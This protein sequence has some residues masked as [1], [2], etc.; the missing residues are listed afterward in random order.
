MPLDLAVLG[1]DPRFGGGGLAQTNAFLDGAAAL[2]R[3]PELLYDAHP[4]LGEPRLTWR[5][6]EALRQLRAARRLA[7]AA[8]EARSLWVA[9]SLAQHGGAAP[10]TGRRYGCWIGT[11]IESEWRGRAAGLPSVHRALAGASLRTLRRIERRVLAGATRLYA[12]SPASRDSVAAA[13]GIDPGDVSILPI[14]IDVD[15]FTPEPDDAWLARLDAPLVA[16]LGRTDDPRKYVGLL[17][18]AF[19]RV[20]AA[21]PEARLRVIGD[22]PRGPAGPWVESTGVVPDVAPLL[23]ECA[24]LV[25]PARQEGFGIGIAEALAC[26][27]PAVV[28]PS[29]G[30]EELVRRSGGGHVTAGFSRDELAAAILAALGDRARLAEQ[31]RAGREHVAAEHAPARF[32]QLLDD[33]LRDLDG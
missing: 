20:H 9:T 33:A 16:F 3:T 2:G 28:T 25:S 18:D 5:R 7:P 13:A 11:T 19:A 29:G 6:V 4:G 10:R 14:P 27:V 15:R 22:A 26:G 12:T 30:P 21:L 17:L 32:R 8:R 1:Q 31:R 24:L 23:R